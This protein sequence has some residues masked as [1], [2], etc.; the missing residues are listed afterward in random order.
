MK[1]DY[2]SL[3]PAQKAKHTR[4]FNKIDDQR[5]AAYQIQWEVYREKSAELHAQIEPQVEQIRAEA[6]A[7]VTELRQQIEEISKEQSEQVGA[8]YNS[9]R[10]ACAPQFK[11]YEEAS[12]LAHK[13]KNAKWEAA[14]RDFWKEL[15]YDLEEA[16]KD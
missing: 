5:L 7:K 14:R 16:K 15:G 3:T 12:S 4:L 6:L 10:E 9:V 13:W 2:D 11:D 1:T 8:L